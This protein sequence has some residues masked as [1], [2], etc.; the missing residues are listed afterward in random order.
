ML[1]LNVELQVPLVGVTSVAEGTLAPLRGWFFSW[2][3]TTVLLLMCLQVLLMLK[4]FGAPGTGEVSPRVYSHVLIIVPHCGIFFCTNPAPV[5]LGA[6][7]ML[8]KVHLEGI[9]T[10]KGLLT[11]L[12]FEGG[13]GL[14]MF[15][16]NMSPQTLCGG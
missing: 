6:G 11:F 4:D 5:L 2:P 3:L 16:Y 8:S 15:T 9:G 10:A 13:L 14:Q 12:T 7:G 1:L